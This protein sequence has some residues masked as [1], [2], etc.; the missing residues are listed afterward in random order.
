M[1]KWDFPCSDPVDISID[2][3]ASGSIV[4]SGEPTDT[5][6]V[7][8]EPSRRGRAPDLL[9]DVQV[10]FEDGQLYIRGPRGISFRPRT[11]LDLTI[12]APAGSS[13]AAKTA[14]ANLSCVGVVSA[15]SMNS[16]SGDVTAATVTGDVTVRSASGDV[17]LDK[18]GGEFTMHTASGHT[19]VRQVSGPVRINSASGDVQIGH[20]G[21]PVTVRT[22]SGDVR[23]DGVG[24][25]TVELSCATGDIRV[26]VVPGIGVYLDLSSVSGSVRSEL[27]E[28]DGPDGGADTAV[29]IRAR[30]MSGDIRITK[31]RTGRPE[32][33]SLEPV[34][35]GQ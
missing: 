34:D 32:S 14:S 8:I 19:Q 17:L 5:V 33:A 35:S 15:L 6:I 24:S 3:W 16:A 11:G 13:C 9:D 26:A 25:G 2:G 12:K 7:E 10:A 18:V 30:T 20:C 4:V 21:G 27:D 23:L 1:T 29:E 28:V 31:A 22:A